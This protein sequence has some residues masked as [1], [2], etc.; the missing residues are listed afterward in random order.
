MNGTR[1][2]ENM[3][4]HLINVAT[5]RCKSRNSENVILQWD[6]TKENCIT[7]IVYASSEMDLYMIKFGVLCSRPIACMKQRFVTSMTYTNA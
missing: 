3:S 2:G 4:P 7:C 1:N 5:L 6:I